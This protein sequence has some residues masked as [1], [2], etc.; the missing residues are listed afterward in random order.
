MLD[1]RMDCIYRPDGPDTEN[2]DEVRTQSRTP[3]PLSSRPL[4]PSVVGG[5]SLP[6]M[7]GL[8][9]LGTPDVYPSEMEIH[10]SL[11]C[12]IS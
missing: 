2:P 6:E 7:N 9:T 12:R 4:Q 11:C 8:I 10:R 3:H 5:T 1:N